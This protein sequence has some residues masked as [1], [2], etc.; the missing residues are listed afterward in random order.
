[1]PTVMHYCLL[2]GQFVKKLYRATS[3]Q[4]RSVDSVAFDSN[5]NGIEFKFESNL[6]SNLAYLRLNS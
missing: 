3:V 2:F 6:E 4:F 5:V 1:V